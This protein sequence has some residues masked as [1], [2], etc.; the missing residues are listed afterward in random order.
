MVAMYAFQY[1]FPWKSSDNGDHKNTGDPQ[2]GTNNQRVSFKNPL[3]KRL[4][5]IRIKEEQWLY[6]S[7][8]AQILGS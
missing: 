2:Q 7:S 4:A 1:D 6:M 5:N 3:Q 8:L